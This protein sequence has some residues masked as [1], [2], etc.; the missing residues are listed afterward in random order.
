MFDIL[1]YLFKN[2]YTPQACPTADVL[3]KRLAAAG[4][5]YDDIDEAI[6][7]LLGLAETTEHCV[8]LEQT[9]SKGMRIYAEF[10]Q[11]QLC[12]EVIGF[13]S[14]LETTNVLPPPLREIVIERALACTD[15]T[16]SLERVK[17]IALMVLWSQE[18]DI[19]YLIL[20]EL[21]RHDSDPLL[22]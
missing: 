2:Y 1:V 8:N 19:D 14:F 11:Q 18:A 7:W 10:E 16:V 4:F 13:I 9:Q 15:T 20:E 12:P 6:R 22:H 17:V 3:A 21:L 5:E